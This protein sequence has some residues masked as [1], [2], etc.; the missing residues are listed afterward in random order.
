MYLK[1]VQGFR[2]VAAL[3]VAIYHI[4]F[5]RVSGGVDAFFVVAGFFI[6]LGFQKKETTT[7]GDVVT[8]W[9]RT[10]AR[11]VPSAGIVIL[12]TCLLFSLFGTDILTADRIKSAIASIAFVENWWLAQTG[13]NYLSIGQTPSP[14]QQFWALSVQIQVY[15][16]LPIFAYRVVRLSLQPNK[17]QV[18]LAICSAALLATFVY[19]LYETHRYQPAAYFNTFARLWEFLAGGLLAML[20]PVLTLRE[21]HARVL[22]YLSLLVLVG[23]AA[24]VPVANAF[25]GA[26]ALVPVLAT[27]GIIVASRNRSNNILLN[28]APMQRLGDLSFTFY[29]WHWPIYIFVW[30]QTGTPDV[31]LPVGLLILGLSLLLAVLTF[32]LFETPFRSLSVVKNRLPTALVACGLAMMPAAVVAVSW[33]A[34]FKSGQQQA[35]QNIEAAVAGEPVDDLVPPLTM[36]KADIPVSYLD[37]CYQK[38][39]ASSEVI[40]C[41]YG[42]PDGAWTVAL[43]G[44]SHSL[45]W[46]PA[47]REIAK[48]EPRLRIVNIAKS[49]CPFTL[50]L[51]EIAS[52]SKRDACLDWNRNVVADLK[53]MSPDLVITTATRNLGGSESI[54]V[55]Y[56]QVWKALGDMPVLAIRDNPSAPFD[57][58]ACVDRLGPNDPACDVNRPTM[59]DAEL[60]FGDNVTFLDFQDF[61]CDA[62]RCPATRDNVL[63]YRDAHHISATASRLLAPRL[64]A[65]LRTVLAKS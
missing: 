20:L 52:D 36:V 35:L 33:G 7:F 51:D 30:D 21:R 46:L 31:S 13:A 64:D 14:F 49:S 55:G 12:A 58:A 22:S 34:L 11:I 43:V 60:E 23:F 38:D 16:L 45:Q 57:I 56:R 54:P 65:V 9:R 53:T 1:E 59:H 37:G 5:H 24:V 47:L 25:P 18:A 32:R 10:L 2:A 28:N 62:T 63:L 26:A 48:K 41:A 42:N 15:A 4:W 17:R 29:L 50:S 40:S 6:F 27:C 8:Y 44:G 3:L 39:F 61:F 19:A